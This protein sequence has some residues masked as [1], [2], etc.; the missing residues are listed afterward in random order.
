MAVHRDRRGNEV[1]AAGGEAVALLDDTFEA[2]LGFR[3]ATGDLLKSALT[4]DRDMAMAS[5]TKG[6]FLKLFADARFAPKVTSAIE[7]AHRSIAAR[8][9][10][11]RES[12][13]LA[14]LETWHKTGL[15][16]ATALWDGILADHPRDV[17]ALRLAHLGHFYLGSAKAMLDSLDRAL[18]GWDASVPG[19]GFL[20]G[21]RAFA[22]EEA[23]ELEA[24][25]AVGRQALD[26][27]PKDLWAAHAVAHTLEMR[28]QA[29]RGIAFLEALEDR[30]T[31]CNNF[32][33]HVHWHRAL[34][35][36]DLAH[37][38]QVLD[39]YDKRIRAEPNDEYLDICNG[40]SM[41]WR[42]QEEG[43][44]VGPRWEE[45]AE[46]ATARIK[47]RDLLFANMH[48]LMA[49]TA[50]GRRE[51]AADLVTVLEDFAGAESSMMAAVAR[52]VAL[53]LGRA[54][55]ALQDGQSAAALDLLL[56]ARPEFYR[57][58]GS[59]AQRDLFERMAVSA[60]LSAGRSAIAKDLLS[61]RLARLPNHRWTWQR[62]AE[63]LRL[64]GEGDAARDATARAAAC[65]AA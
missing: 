11:D 19:Y 10:T 64:L 33:G 58:G 54:M 44:D 62:Y 48:Y 57:I 26:M 39:L 65:L 43:V 37:H 25:E 22:L 20:M 5:I 23:G 46:R 6:C 47:D 4:A 21:C 14:A 49:L 2:F 36:L 9:A 1:T 31:D 24:A 18:P 17:L 59:H 27:N 34:F 41:L 60:A 13:H 38:D 45:L 40:A 3:L 30:W 51:A 8:G 15:L 35:H 32:S 52:D 42:L 12:R 61:E 29:R 28:G 63:T 7:T 53:P 16:E 50:S 55:L 56:Q